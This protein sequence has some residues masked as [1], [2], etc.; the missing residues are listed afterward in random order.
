ERRVRYNSHRDGA[1]PSRPVQLEECPSAV[2]KRN[3]RCTTYLARTA[4]PAHQVGG[5]PLARALARRHPAL[6]NYPI[7]MRGS[8]GNEDG[9]K[10]VAKRGVQARTD[11][12]NGSCRMRVF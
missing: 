5:E 10:N 1:A 2:K 4:G 8:A 12:D 9:C 6:L 11:K 3:R 7:V